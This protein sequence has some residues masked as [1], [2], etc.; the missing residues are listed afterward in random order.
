MEDI[1]TFVYR[2]KKREREPAQ[3]MCVIILMLL[4]NI[5]FNMQHPTD[6]NYLK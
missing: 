6:T 4:I 3:E 5:T 1:D 2:E